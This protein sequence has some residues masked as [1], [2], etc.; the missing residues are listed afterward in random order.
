MQRGLSL[1][2][3]QVCNCLI[4]HSARR[5]FQA[6]VQLIAVG[7]AYFSALAETGLGGAATKAHLFQSDHSCL[8][9]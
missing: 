7:Y 9:S 3:A 4:T 5:L 1:Y 2:L 8:Y 6:Y